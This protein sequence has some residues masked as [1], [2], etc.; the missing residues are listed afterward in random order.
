[1]VGIKF[2]D[3]AVGGSVLI[4]ADTGTVY[5]LVTQL[6]AD[7]V[8]TGLALQTVLGETVEAHPIDFGEL[9][10]FIALGAGEG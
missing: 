8:A 3:E 1:M 2:T 4:T 6:A 9:V 10:V 7:T 5:V